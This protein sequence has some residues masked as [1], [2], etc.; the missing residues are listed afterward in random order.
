MPPIFRFPA[1]KLIEQAIDLFERRSGIRLPLD[2]MKILTFTIAVMCFQANAAELFVDWSLDFSGSIVSCTPDLMIRCINTKK[3]YQ[4]MGRCDANE[5]SL[6]HRCLLPK[7]ISGKCYIS[8]AHSATRQSLDGVY[9]IEVKSPQDKLHVTMPGMSTRFNFELPR[10]FASD[11][12]LEIQL[13][14]LDERNNPL[15]HWL[16]VADLSPKP[17]RKEVLT[18]VFTI[19]FL[20]EGSYVACI[21]SRDD[22]LPNGRR[23]LMLRRMSVQ[24]DDVIMHKPKWSLRDVLAD[25]R[26]VD[27]L[28]NETDVFDGVSAFSAVNFGLFKYELIG[29]DG[30]AIEK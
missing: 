27:I 23:V 1:L 21:L 9:E 29:L 4:I 18:S 13:F 10:K 7:E 14:R 25:K 16:H 3:N 6:P 26:Q 22:T 24:T 11:D 20:G 15:P 5:K 12:I 8:L 2:N 28:L 19:P 30:V 17:D